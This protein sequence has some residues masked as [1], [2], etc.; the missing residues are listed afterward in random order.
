ME[1]KEEVFSLIHD[2]D[3]NLHGNSLA[4]KV[5]AILLKGTEMQN[6]YDLSEFFDFP[7]DFV[8]GVAYRLQDN[9]IWKNGKTYCD[10]FDGD[11]GI[12]AFWSD[13]CCGTGNLKRVIIN[14]E[15]VFTNPTHI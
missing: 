15:V 4:F 7:L 6:V 1:T 10:W 2:L 11:E 3:T 5:T 12:I 8:K 9:K 13:V 14:N